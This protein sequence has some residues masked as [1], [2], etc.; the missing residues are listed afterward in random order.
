MGK[1]RRER[2]WQTPARV[3]GKLVSTSSSRK[4]I[5]CCA[6][7]S[8]FRRSLCAARIRAPFQSMPCTSS[9]P[10]LGFAKYLRVVGVLSVPPGLDGIACFSFLNRFHYGN[11]GDPGL[12][13][14][15]T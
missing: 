12:F 15:E 7:A 13:G 8:I 3:H 14:L 5:V 2:C 11:F 4:T 6:A 9:F 1:R 10:A